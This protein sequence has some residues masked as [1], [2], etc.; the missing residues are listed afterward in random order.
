MLDKRDKFLQKQITDLEDQIKLALQ[1]KDKKTA[2]YLLK[3]KKLLEKQQEG[4]MGKRLNLDTQKMQL[5][6]AAMNKQVLMGMKS[7]ADTMKSLVK[8]G[9]IDSVDQIAEEI[10]EA[11]A[12]AEEFSDALSQPLGQAMDNDELNAELDAMESELNGE[13]EEVVARAQPSY[14]LPSVPVRSLVSAPAAAAAA[15]PSKAKAKTAEEA[16]LEAL[17]FEMGMG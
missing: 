11:N 10:Q 9:D 5:E 3:K 4:I 13:Q 6:D 1:K 7:F 16:E 14:D 17:E 15:V 12:L 2:L 8:E